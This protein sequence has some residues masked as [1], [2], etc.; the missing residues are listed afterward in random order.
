MVDRF[1]RRLT[2]GLRVLGGFL[3]LVLLLALAV[4]VIVI[5][6]RLL[7]GRLMQATD[8]EARTQQALLRAS[9]HVE[10]SRVNL[11]R[12][13][14]DYLPSSAS[15]QDDVI[16][17]V[18]Y[19][20][21]ARPNIKSP[22]QRATLAALAQTL[23]EYRTLARNVE[24]A[25][26]RGDAQETTRLLFQA[27]KTG[28]DIDQQIE[29]VVRIS[30]EQITASNA[31]AQAEAQARL[32][33][34]SVSIGIVLALALG[35]GVTVS[36]SITRPVSELRS[37]AE[38]FSQGHL[39][40]TLPVAGADELSM[41]ARTFNQMSIQLS[42][43]HQELEKR[44][45]ERTAEIERHS[46]YLEASAE[47][48]RA[49]TS[50]LETDELIRRLVDLIRE[51][52]GLYYVGLFEADARNDWAVLKAGT[53]EAGQA[54]LARGHRLHIGGDSMIGWCIANAQARVAAEAGTE[55]IR[56][57]T[58]ELP[59]TRSEAAL[60]L[61]SRGK[62]IGALTVQSDRPS[63]FDTTALSALQSMADQVTVAIDNA[64][65]FA[66]NQAALEAARREF[67]EL[68]RSAWAQFMRSQSVGYLYTAQGTLRAQDQ[69]QPDMAQAART[70]QLV[71]AHGSTVAVPIQIRD[72]VLGVL[73]LR[74]Q[75]NAPAWMPEELALLQ[76]LTEQLSVALESARL[77]QDTQRRA[78]QERL[79]G[80]VTA[81]MSET[82]DMETVLR[83]AIR[84]MGEA[85]SMTEVEVRM[86]TPTDGNGYSKSN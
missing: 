30:E 4:P 71:Q 23:E 79:V 20:D 75:D 46:A 13:I 16:R 27:Y 35:L 69:W 58:T 15:A 47:V 26:R 51:R 9:V 24:T 31:A 65:L 14:Q 85:L 82:L 63:A 41:L 84:E 10:A 45:A 70:G 53:G 22:E 32:W 67:G 42:R 7:A 1:L 73:R 66:E 3:V 64:R 50:I 28:A 54:M 81:R 56:A 62:V 18:E 59:D 68:S 2:V 77:Y 12:Y 40:T 5:D 83:T 72:Q 8:V 78:A 43:S 36:R 34:L 17:A 52:F 74:K 38:A 21:E 60:P 49:A 48:G 11:S 33:G 80:Q 25:R 19:L 44:V 61:R 39:E 37:G 6:H 57:A 29:Q 55:T 76:S 86:G